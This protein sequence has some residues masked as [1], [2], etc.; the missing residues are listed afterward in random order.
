MTHLGAR[1]ALDIERLDSFINSL[2]LIQGDFEKAK[3][4]FNV[5]DYYTIL[6]SLDRARDIKEKLNRVV[7]RQV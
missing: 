4:R 3:E 5:E 1:L 2:H 6:M 7:Q